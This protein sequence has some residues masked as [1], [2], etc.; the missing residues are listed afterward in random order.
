MCFMSVLVPSHNITERPSWQINM[1]DKYVNWSWER[2][3]EKTEFEYGNY[4]NKFTYVLW[5]KVIWG[6]FAIYYKKEKHEEILQNK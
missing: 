1:S 2:M 6:D 4:G 5:S 3:I